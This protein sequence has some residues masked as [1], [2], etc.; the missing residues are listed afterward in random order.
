MWG[1][2]GTDDYPKLLAFLLASLKPEKRSLKKTSC[3]PS[4]RTWALGRSNGGSGGGTF[5]LKGDRER[6]QPASPRLNH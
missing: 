2:K 6:N 3:I 4:H 1:V 5:G